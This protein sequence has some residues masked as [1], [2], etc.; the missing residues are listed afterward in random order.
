MGYGNVYSEGPV[1][2]SPLWEEDRHHCTRS[3]S[4]D[5]WRETKGLL[6]NRS[7]PLK[8]IQRVLNQVQDQSCC[9]ILNTVVVLHKKEMK[10][11]LGS[12]DQTLQVW[13]HLE[14]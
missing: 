10:G 8:N 13:H 11:L 7:I 1:H 9:T 14:R 6:V 2:L 5:E 12:F 3:K 4:M